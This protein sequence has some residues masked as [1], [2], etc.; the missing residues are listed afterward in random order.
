MQFYLAFC[1][2]VADEYSIIQPLAPNHPAVSTTTTA[3]VGDRGDDDDDEDDYDDR[4]GHE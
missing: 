2:A 1:C 4:G 3:P